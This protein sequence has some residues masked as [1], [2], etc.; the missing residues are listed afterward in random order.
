[1]EITA[2]INR[3]KKIITITMPLQKA[4]PSQSSGK[5]LVVGT[6]HGCKTTEARH[7]RRPI[8]VTAN[9]FIYATVRP[10]RKQHKVERRPKSVRVDVGASGPK[11]GD[12]GV[13]RR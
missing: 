11:A 12:K 4:T 2:K 10:E 8:V 7:S 6:T 13:E 1:M 9:A 3:R 5:T